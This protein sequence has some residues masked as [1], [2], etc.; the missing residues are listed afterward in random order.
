[1]SY[2]LVCGVCDCITVVHET[3]ESDEIPMFC[4]MC[5]TEIEADQIED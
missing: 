2:E 4:P 1:M 5:G 3:T